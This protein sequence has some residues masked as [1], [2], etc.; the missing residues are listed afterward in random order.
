[1]FVGVLETLFDIDPT[2][3][4][5][6]AILFVWWQKKRTQQIFSS[7]HTTN[8]S[9]R[10]MAAASAAWRNFSRRKRSFGFEWEAIKNLES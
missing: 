7:I 10:L 1:M 9:V 8:H 4:Q 2:N 3:P 6:A 5:L